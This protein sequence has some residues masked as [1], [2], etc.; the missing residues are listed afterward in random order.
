MLLEK[1]RRSLE[2]SGLLRRL[3]S[4][5]RI[6]PIQAVDTPVVRPRAILQLDLAPLGLSVPVEMT[7]IG[8]TINLFEP[9]RPLRLID[10]CRAA[11]TS[12]PKRSYADI[13]QALHESVMTVKRAFDALRRMKALEI[14]EPWRVL[15]ASPERASRWRSR[16]RVIDS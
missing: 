16:K 3:L 4:D 2:L 1:S 9:S 12:D 7:V 13:A 8:G 6:Q 14:S 5:F 10:A 11:K 15:E